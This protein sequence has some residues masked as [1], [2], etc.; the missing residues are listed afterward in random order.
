[1]PKLYDEGAG[2]VHLRIACPVLLFPCPFL[3]FSV[4]RSSLDLAGRTAVFALEG[5]ED[6][7]YSRYVDENSDHHH[8]MVE[9]IRQRMQVNSLVY[10]RM[11]DLVKAIGLPKEKL[12]THCW[13]NSSTF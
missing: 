3:N 8:A 11:A 2:E 9:Q 7:D 1:M 10:Q 13:D 4:S 12:C 5:K 6:T